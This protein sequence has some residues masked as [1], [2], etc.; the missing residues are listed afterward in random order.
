MR[1]SLSMVIRPPSAVFQSIIFLLAVTCLAGEWSDDIRLTE[2]AQE[3]H[4]IRMASDSRSNIHF[5]W[6]QKEI[7][8]DNVCYAKV[9]S[10]GQVV[11]TPMKITDTSGPSWTPNLVVDSRDN[12][13]IFWREIGPTGFDVWYTKLDTVGET[14]IAPMMVIDA[15]GTNLDW[16]VPAV[17]VDCQDNLHLVWDQSD[18]N[19][20]IHYTKLDDEGN[21]L[22]EDIY[23]S[24][25]GYDARNHALAVDCWGNVHVAWAGGSGTPAS[26]ELTYSKLDNNGNILIDQLSLTPEPDGKNSRAPDVVIDSEGN[27]HICFIDERDL[28]NW[29]VWYTKLDNNGQ[30]LIEDTNL[31]SSPAEA[32]GPRFAIDCWDTLHLM[33]PDFN[34][35]RLKG[36]IPYR[37]M[38]KDGVI[39]DSLDLVS[40]PSAGAGDI[41]TSPNGNV[42]VAW[43]DYRNGYE[44]ECV[45]FKYYDADCGCPDVS[46]YLTPDEAMVPRGGKLGLD[47]LVRNNTGSSQTF[48]AWT[49]VILPNGKPYKGNPVLGPKMVP[50][51][52]RKWVIRHISQQVP[53]NAPLGDYIYM[54]SV[55]TWPDSLIDQDAFTFVVTEAL[56]AGVGKPG[57]SEVVKD[58]AVIEEGDCSREIRVPPYS[59]P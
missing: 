20:E 6:K 32:G 28:N 40:E 57:T 36:I 54:G 27:V 38:T 4:S 24:W 18:D 51:Q 10:C 8:I 52:P 34:T 23:L 7:D 16:L 12:V 3:A 19:S 30:T 14:V 33:W 22:V 25:Q 13:H 15:M 53:G 1:L 31:T 2:G 41:T 44:N 55:G 17:G 35:L 49:G 29:D 39:V 59:F 48:Q 26:Y 43:R 56:T 50:L 5:V 46:V 58:W 37:K 21:V 47:I 45:Y 42:T 11:K 9:D